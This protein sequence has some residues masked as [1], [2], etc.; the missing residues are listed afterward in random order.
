VP[1]FE[2][3]EPSPAWAFFKKSAARST[4]AAIFEASGA[5]YDMPLAAIVPASEH[6]TVKRLINERC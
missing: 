5:A 3:N 4:A 6:K 2:L 1:A